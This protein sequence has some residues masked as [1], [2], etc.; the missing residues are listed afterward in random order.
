MGDRKVLL[1][2]KW[3]IAGVAAAVVTAGLL[4]PAPRAQAQSCAAVE[5]VVARG[6][7]EPGYLGSAVGDPLF[8]ALRERLP[9]DVD[10]YRVNYPADLTDPASVGD[11][12]ADLVA[13][14]VSQAAACPAQRF[15]LAGYSQGAAV[16]HTAL[17]TG[18]T[19]DIPGAVRLPGELGARVTAVLLFGDPMRLVGW[20]V[21]GPYLGRTGNW[22]APGDPVCAGGLDPQAHVVAYAD[23]M[24]AAA[25][26]TADRL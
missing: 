6:T 3:R 5:V 20:S 24:G 17:G 14:M 10:G 23:D 2:G 26:F 12:S 25:N 1:S 11:G 22:C 21:P 16:V 9:V 8:A 19:D 4:Y 13:H 15:V 18:L 7:Q